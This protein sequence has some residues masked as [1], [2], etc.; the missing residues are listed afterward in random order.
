MS[1]PTARMD[2]TESLLASVVTVGTISS[3]V[4]LDGTRTIPAAPA[5]AISAAHWAERSEQGEQ[6]TSAQM[7]ATQ[8]QSS[9]MRLCR[10]M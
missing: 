3:L 9:A 6:N 7:N 4:L 10:K 5:S 1:D 2:E 8:S